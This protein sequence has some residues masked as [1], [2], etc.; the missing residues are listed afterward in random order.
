MKWDIYCLFVCNHFNRMIP[1]DDFLAF[2]AKIIFAL[3]NLINLKMQK[4]FSSTK[5]WHFP[6]FVCSIHQINPSLP[7][8]ESLFYFCD[9]Q[10]SYSNSYSNSY[11]TYTVILYVEWCNITCLLCLFC[12]RYCRKTTGIRNIDN[13]HTLKKTIVLNLL[14]SVYQ[15]TLIAH[16]HILALLRKQTLLWSALLG[17]VWALCETSVDLDK[18]RPGNWTKALLL[19]WHCYLAKSVTAK[20][21]QLY[22]TKQDYTHTHSQKA[23]HSCFAAD[24]LSSSRSKADLIVESDRGVWESGCKQ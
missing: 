18:S 5:L 22:A 13:I 11:C 1:N 23:Q 9:A 2:L 16:A 4:N 3:V 20:D 8:M 19:A 17:A 14:V 6:P 15:A 12:Q 21:R 7:N 10:P 24:C